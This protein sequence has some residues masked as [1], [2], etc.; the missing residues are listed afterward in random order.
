MSNPIYAIPLQTIENQS[1]T[2]NA[3]AGKVLLVVNVASECGLTKQYEGLEKL[4]ETWRE[5]GFAVLGFPSNEFLGQEPGSN[6]EI[7]AFCRGTFG[8]QFPMFAKIEVNGEGRHPLYRELIA[9]QPQ[10][11]APEG[12][13]F[14]ERMSSKGRAPKH[15]GDILWNFEKF[16]I[17]RDGTV[18]QRFSPDMTPEDPQVSEAIKQALAK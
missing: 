16:L 2:L 1:T 11:V 18:I 10:A 15:T 4:Y 8:V 13:G 6:E 12:S 3:Y 14:L 7:L 5:Q 9:A 17:G